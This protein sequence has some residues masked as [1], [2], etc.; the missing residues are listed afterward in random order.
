MRC[1]FG[2]EHDQASVMPF[3]VHALHAEDAHEKRMGIGG[4]G[5]AIVARCYAMRHI[6]AFDRVRGSNRC[7]GEPKW[8]GVCRFFVCDA[9]RAFAVARFAFCAGIR[10]APSRRG[11]C[12]SALALCAGIRV[13]PTRRGRCPCA[14]RHLLFF[15]AAKKSRQKKAAHPASTCTYPTGP[16]RPHAFHGSTLAHASCQ[17]ANQR[18]THFAHPYEEQPPR[19]FQAT[20]RQTLCRPS[21]R[22]GHHWSAMGFIPSAALYSEIPYTSLPQRGVQPKMRLAAVRAREVGEAPTSRLAT[23]RSQNVG[24]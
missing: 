13:A 20:M 16:Q 23:N 11:R 3:A 7:R 12:S 14:G 24:G 10:V 19:M 5:D 18:L 21:H 22:T 2:F 9:G 15:A 6:C 17:R 4:C 1:A 8:F